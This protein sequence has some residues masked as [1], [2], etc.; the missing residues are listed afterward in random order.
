MTRK[1]WKAI[2][3]TMEAPEQENFKKSLHEDFQLSV[4]GF[5]TLDNVKE[6]ILAS[7]LAKLD[8]DQQ[9]TALR[10]VISQFYPETLSEED[11]ASE[12]NKFSIYDGEDNY[13]L[14]YGLIPAYLAMYALT[15][16]EDSSEAGE[17]LKEAEHYADMLKTLEEE[18]DPIEMDRGAAAVADLEEKEQSHRWYP[19]DMTELCPATPE[20]GWYIGFF[21]VASSDFTFFCFITITHW[22]GL[23]QGESRPL[24][25]TPEISSRRMGTFR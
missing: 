23:M 8:E 9:R 6:E 22:R 2:L 5:R 19:A 16:K 24:L 12:I 10:N 4:P 21:N 20:E 14:H 18:P 1:Y 3:S 13:A 17:M 15:G 11:Y 25:K 7:A